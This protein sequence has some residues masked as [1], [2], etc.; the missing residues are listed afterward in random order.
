M[1]KSKIIGLI[2]VAFILVASSLL[3]AFTSTDKNVQYIK[4]SYVSGMN[5]QTYVIESREEL[6]EYLNANK[7]QYGLGHR[8]KVYSDSTIGFED[9]IEDY[10]E[11][12]FKDHNIVLVLLTANSGSIR[13]KATNVN[14]NEG[15]M[16]IS[17]TQKAPEMVTCDMAGWHIIVETEKVSI[18][19]INVY[20]EGNELIRRRLLWDF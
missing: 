15:K 12:W 18:D 19:E 5:G 17:F 3:V 11:E 1:K 4:T 14:I 9:A 20:V 13:F 6:E 7:K 16:D 8:E 2:V 10:D